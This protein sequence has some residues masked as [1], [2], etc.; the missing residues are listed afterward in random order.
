MI[1]ELMSEIQVSRNESSLIMV[2]GVGGAG[3]NAVSNMWHAGV[4]NVTYLACNTDQKSLNVN[5]VDNKIRLG[6]EGLGAGNRPERAREA[7]IVSLD[8]IRRCITESGCRMA[9]ITAGM[10]GGTGTGAAPVIAKLSKELGLLTVGI[11]TSPL[12]SEGKKRWK[13]AMEAI[14]ELEQ[15]V[16]ALLVIDN[17]NVVRAY[18]ELPLH[19]AFSRADDV[20]STATRGIAEI[21]TRESDLVGVDFAD[22][23]EV[24]RN[25]GRAHMSVTS[26]CGENRVDE[27][28][29]ASLCS[30][31]LGHLEIAG[32]KN[33]LLNF[34]VPDS[35][36]LKT[37]EVT[38][39]LD[40]IQHYANAG[41]KNVGLSETN[42]IWGTSINPQ[43]ES[44]TLELVII[45]T[46]FEVSESNSKI[47]EWGSSQ[48]QEDHSVVSKEEIGTK[49]EMTESGMVDDGEALQNVWGELSRKVSGWVNRVFEGADTPME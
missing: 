33:I 17:D 38:Q 15:N 20:L 44:G 42:I 39:V 7:A 36:E 27:V 23:T 43:M 14:A 37:R 26:A 24:M 11:V 30:P 19:E 49:K 47:S 16:D 22:V 46:G 35:D 34:S 21:V 13:Q 32:A 2:I 40:R 48:M 4:K 18:D 9:F 5:P 28:L 31:L 3:C 1:D 45:A 41:R 8:D 10:G 6:N 12:A 29:K 25:C